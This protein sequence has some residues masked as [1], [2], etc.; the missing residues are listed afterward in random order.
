M[1]TR[2]DFYADA[3]G[4]NYIEDPTYPEVLSLIN[5]LNKASNTFVVFY[6]ADPA[7][8]WFISVATSR[9]PLGGYEVERYDPATGEKTKTTTA[10]PS[11]IAT[12]VLA[13]I[14]DR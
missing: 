10:A 8:Q 12:D 2:V 4:G 1:L 7:N 6:P 3:E 11:Q 9:G 5:T 14:N 13:W